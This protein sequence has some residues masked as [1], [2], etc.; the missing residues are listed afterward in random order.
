MHSSTGRWA[1]QGFPKTD[2]CPQV[3]VE[4]LESFSWGQKKAPSPFA[5]A[6]LCVVLRRLEAL[7]GEI[8]EVGVLQ[9]PSSK[10]GS[11]RAAPPRRM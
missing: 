11:G 6:L 3:T 1:Y 7:A 9:L 8:A 2:I 4:A 5:T 10:G